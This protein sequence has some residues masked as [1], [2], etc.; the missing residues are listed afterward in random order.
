MD[1]RTDEK[2]ARRRQLLAWR[3]SLDEAEKAARDERIRR[4]L[5]GCLQR[6]RGGPAGERPVGL[7]AGLP[8]DAPGSG[9]GSGT[10]PAVALY[11]PVRGEVDLTPLWPQLWAAGW[12]VALPCTRPAARE[13]WFAEVGPATCLAPGPYGIPE[14]VADSPTAP[15]AAV[16]RR[17]LAVVVVPGL[18]FTRS[19]VRL[20]YGGGYYD[21]LFADESVTAVRIGVAYDRQVLDNLPADPHDARLHLLVTEAGVWDCRAAAD[22]GVCSGRADGEA[23]KVLRTLRRLHCRRMTGQAE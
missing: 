7:P 17:E 18:A 10:R 23:R 21:R 9:S 8:A 15:A 11:Y 3:E 13:L 12:R 22:R 2:A 19:G 1:G 16:A 6:L 14:P 5:G 20:G 4:H